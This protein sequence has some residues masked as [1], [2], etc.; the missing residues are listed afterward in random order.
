ME[1]RDLEALSEVLKSSL[2]KAVRGQLKVGL[3]FLGHIFLGWEQH[4][5]E[6]TI[7]CLL[8]GKRWTT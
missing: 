3:S 7:P 8:W 1:A 5:A 4:R 6:N 2:M